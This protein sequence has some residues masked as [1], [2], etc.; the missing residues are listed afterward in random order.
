MAVSS[1]PRMRIGPIS[2]Q[3][4]KTAKQQNNSNIKTDNKHTQNAQCT[5]NLLDQHISARPQNLS[6]NHRHSPS[7]N[8][9]SPPRET[10]LLT[11]SHRQTRHRQRAARSASYAAG[12]NAAAS[13][14]AALL[15]LGP[16]IE[17]LQQ[18]MMRRVPRWDRGRER[19]PVQN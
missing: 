5:Q 10:P 6:P 12:P 7:R 8:I 16:P 2:I 11:T 14:P 15:P 13:A 19:R 17:L 4:N 18:P 1:F 3:N 9:S